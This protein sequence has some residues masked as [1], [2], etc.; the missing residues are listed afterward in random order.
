[1]KCLNGKLWTDVIPENLKLKHDFGSQ[2][3]KINKLFTF[4]ALG[5]F[6]CLISQQSLT[7]CKNKNNSFKEVQW[8]K[9]IEDFQQHDLLMMAKKYLLFKEAVCFYQ[10]SYISS[11][12]S[13]NIIVSAQSCPVYFYITACYSVG[14]H[15]T[16]D[17]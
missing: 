7:E 2:L 9:I 16:V 14:H 11:Q 10:K 12:L 8:C 15:I 5:S 3:Q 17:E 1:M 13:Y 4:I 6:P